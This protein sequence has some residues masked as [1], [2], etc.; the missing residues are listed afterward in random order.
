MDERYQNAFVH[1]YI[2]NQAYYRFSLGN[3]LPNLNK[4]IYLDADT[5]CFKDL[6]KFYDLNFRGKIILGKGLSQNQTN[7]KQIYINSGIL[8]LN[9]KKMRKMKIEKKV[10]NILNS[11]FKH[12]TLHDQ[13]V[14][15][16]FFYKYVGLL[17]P[18]FNSYLLNYT[19]TYKV[20]STV[21][22]YDKDKM[23]FSLKYPT[24][25]HYKGDEKHLNDDW[26]YFARMSKY[27]HKISKNYSQIFNLSI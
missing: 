7:K 27:F 16:T 20:I 19:E 12:P 8:L 10:L 5:I 21:K 9:L 25:R 11:G 13:A 1:R 6:S 4:I 2:T 23:L 3:L 22:L 18:E 15:D 24:I 14:I 17:P 26:Y